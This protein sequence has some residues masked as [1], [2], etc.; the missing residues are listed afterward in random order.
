VKRLVLLVLALAGLAAGVVAVHQTQPAWY[1]E[2]MPPAVARRVY[3]LEHRAAIRAAAARN[4][5]DPALVAGLIYV[6]SGYRE[7]AVS[8]EGAVGL[9]QVLPS[10]A[11]EIAARTGGVRFRSADLGDPRVNIRY[12]SR[13][14]RMLLDRYDGSRLD[15]V[16]AYNA[17]ARNVDAWRR[18]A[19]GR[20]TAADI[21]FA[22]TRNYVAEVTRLAELY[23][24]AYAEEL[25]AP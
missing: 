16:A 8:S 3:P 21:E 18:A 2:H 14:L 11:R 6:E 23:G 10:T 25:Q 15:A 5:L 1:V 9:M 24:R 13:Y 20:L 19:G 4:R 22:E 7:D 17:G 12:G